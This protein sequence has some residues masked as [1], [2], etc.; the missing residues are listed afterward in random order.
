MNP[1]PMIETAK[2]RSFFSSVGQVLGIE[3]CRCTLNPSVLVPV[4]GLFGLLP[5]STQ[6]LPQAQEV[7]AHFEANRIYVS[8]VTE[9][10]DTL[11]LFTD[12]GGGRNPILMRKTAER[13]GLS[14]VDTLSQGRRSIP[15]VPF[16]D[17]RDEPSFPNPADRALA[18]P[19]GRRALLH[20]LGDG[21][22]GQSWFADRIWTFDYGAETLLHHP[23]TK[24]MSFDPQH[25]VDLAFQ[26]DSTGRRTSH[27]PRIK[28]TIADSTY[29][30]LFDTGATSVVTDSVR[31]AV[32]W[33][34]VIGSSF[35]TASV[36]EHWRNQHPEWK[37]LEGASVFRGGT[38]MIRVPDVT[39]AGHTVGPVWFERRPDRAFKKGGVARSMD[40]PVNGALGGS[41]LQYFR[42]SV[43]YPGMRALFKRTNT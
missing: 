20:D 3:N 25:T 29:D 36:F 39:I 2:L 23:S 37:V 27:H 24:G 8:P 17:L 21:M 16:P 33:P 35:V 38:P 30:F 10:G 6:P 31:H 13:L 40:Q 41:L 5:F 4:L 15:L 43:D 14:P 11:R 32:G 1:I 42:V 7:S 18:M 26:T 9:Q 19:G 22:L 12:T 28:A 34:G